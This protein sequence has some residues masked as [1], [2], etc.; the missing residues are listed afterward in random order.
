VK[1]FSDLFFALYCMDDQRKA[2][3]LNL[4]H[5]RVLISLFHIKPD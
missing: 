4:V 5:I 3:E 2:D 1:K